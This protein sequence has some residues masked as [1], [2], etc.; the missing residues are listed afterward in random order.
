MRPGIEPGASDIKK[1]GRKGGTSK[2]N[3]EGETGEAGEKSR[4]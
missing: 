4:E 2:G 1:L 3:C